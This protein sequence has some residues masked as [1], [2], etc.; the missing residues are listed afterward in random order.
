MSLF[1]RI[2]R[3]VG[4]AGLIV[5]VVALVCALGGS[6]YAAKNALT[7]AQ[8][9]LITKEARKWAKKF[10]KAGPAGAQ[11]PAGPAGKDGAAGPQG[12]AGP[13]G[14]TGPQG[15]PGES[16]TATEIPPGELECDE[17][18]GAEFKVGSGAPTFAC[19]GEQGS[20]WTAG[21]T[22]PSKA[23]QTGT[24]AGMAVPIEPGF[25]VGLAPISFTIPLE[26]SL[27]AE[28]VK[29]VT[30][31]TPPAECDDPSHPGAPS[32]ENP[33]ADPGYLCVFAQANFAGPPLPVEGIYRPGGAIGVSATKGA[34]R[35]GAVV[36]LASEAE[37]DG[38]YGSYAV[39]AP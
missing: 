22:L 24:W 37:F 12:A 34:G 18:G 7:G 36:S 5:S 10:A 38:V 3:R 15:L 25:L 26:N 4:T 29:L 9:K 6:A 19:N 30:G 1:K 31:G 33:E 23:T 13:T 20:P 8:K 32:T 21:G 28:H 35:S 14:P 16:V 39:T 2:E 11:G 27:D 17:R